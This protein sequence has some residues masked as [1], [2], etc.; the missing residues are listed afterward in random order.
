MAHSVR[1]GSWRSTGFSPWVEEHRPLPILILL[2]ALPLAVW[3]DTRL[4]RF[5]NDVKTLKATFS[6]EVRDE[7]GKLLQKSSGDVLLMRPGR[8]R[9]EYREPFP[10]LI[11]ADGEKLW[12]YDEELE[13]VTVKPQGEALGAAPI[14]LLDRRGTLE[15]QFRITSAGRRDG[16]E[17][18]VLEPKVKDTEFLRVEFGLDDAGIRRMKLLDQFGQTTTIEFNDLRTNSPLSPSLFR[19]EVP[20]G[21]DVIGVAD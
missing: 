19:F 17:W 20:D 6:Q 21:V 11:L 9:W 12:L 2:L 15:E 16:L 7:S 4:D 18:V 8:F 14:A 10:Q 5:F 13:Q 3:G 1:N